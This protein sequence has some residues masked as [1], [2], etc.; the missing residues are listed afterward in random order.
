M[1]YA[2]DNEGN[3]IEVSS[4]GEKGICPGCG[5]NVYGR[6]GMVNKEH[7]YHKVKN[8]DNWYEPITEWHL[9]WQNIFPENYREIALKSETGEIHIADIRLKN[10]MTP[11]YYK[12]SY[13]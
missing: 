10:K 11:R 7:W 6:Y 2:L 5:S 9:N 1:R 4:S 12:F 3:K 8:C 13:I